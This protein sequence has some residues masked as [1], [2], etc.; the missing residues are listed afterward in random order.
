MAYLFYGSRRFALAA[1]RDRLA[2]LYKT[3]K[4]KYWM[5][6]LYENIIARSLLYRGLFRAFTW[7]DSNIIDGA[8]N[9]LAWLGISGGRAARRA[10]TGQLQLYAIIAFF[11]LVVLIITLVL[12]R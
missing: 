3:L 1:V 5:D 4:S 9:G 10:Q 7:F 11:G 12:A 2:P 6:E 8:V